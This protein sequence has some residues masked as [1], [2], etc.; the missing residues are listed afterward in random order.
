MEATVIEEVREEPVLSIKDI[1]NQAKEANAEYM[2]DIDD[3]IT[4][5]PSLSPEKSQT[6]SIS[7][8]IAA[9]KEKSQ[10]YMT[11]PVKQNDT[12]S[13]RVSQIPTGGSVY[14]PVGDKRV[15]SSFGERIHP[16]T[17]KRSFHNGLDFAAP[18]G[19]P[20]TVPSDGEVIF[21]GKK[22]PNGNLVRVRHANG[23]VTAYAHLDSFDVK[24]GDKVTGRM[25]IGT[26][27]NTGRSTGPHLHYAV[28]NSKGEPIDP[29]KASF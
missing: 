26:V 13:V 2:P 3:S 8:I 14:L 22:G 11:P 12:E 15:S 24:K 18:I 10:E 23:M 20:V 5:S 16:I 9:A 25:K 17:G 29:R 28:F 27:G 21:A 6:M 19:T 7:E 1:I 4:V